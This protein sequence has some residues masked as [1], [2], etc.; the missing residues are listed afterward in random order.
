L[1][2]GEIQSA[3]SLANIDPNYITARQDEDIIKRLIL[4]NMGLILN[5]ATDEI[6]KKKSALGRVPKGCVA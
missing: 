5:R 2:I 4:K 3:V 6:T 1:F